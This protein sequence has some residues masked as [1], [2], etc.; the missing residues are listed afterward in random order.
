M[1]NK[2]TQQGIQENNG[3]G[4][5][6]LHQDDIVY[7]RRTQRSAMNCNQSCFWP[8]SED[9][10]VNIP[11]NISTEFSVEQT[12]VI[13]EAMQEFVTLTCIQFISRTT[14]HDY[15]NIFPGDRCWSYFGKI[16]G[17][18]NLGLAKFGCIYKGL[19][20]H[21]LNHAL[22][23][24]HEQAR[25]DRDKY[26]K[27][28][29]EY[30]TAGEQGNFEKVNSN[31]LGLPYDYGSVMHYGPYDFSNAAG[32]PTIVPTPN[33]SVLIGQRV[34]LSNLDVKKIN[35]LYSCNCCSTVLRNPRGNFSS[36][37]YPHS[38]PPNVTCLWLVKIPNVKVFL[39][40]LVFDLQPSPN[41][42]SDYIRI[43]DGNSRNARL[44][45]DKFCGVGQLPAVVSSGS[46]MLVE[47]VSDEDTA[48]KG[49]TAS[50][51][52]VICGGTFTNTSGAV[53][54]PNFPRKYPPDQDCLWIISA[55]PGRRISLRM[56]SF[57]LEYTAECNYDRLVLRDGSQN[58]SPR[59]G[60]FCGKM[61]VPA[62]NSTGSFL[63]VEFYTD[64]AF[65]YSGFKLDY[66]IILPS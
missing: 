65:Q 52:Y 43:Y 10:L 15:I 49:F 28:N 39:K 59:V 36:N 19:I 53:T 50:Y 62:F 11:V 42:A 1:Q 37:N 26:V 13:A 51:T 7:R 32:K 33:A 6:Y 61:E 44:L 14:E 30:V 55:P 54:S 17:R 31:N 57:D 22:G 27:I 38:Y 45:I 34:G 35:M 18:Q 25:G 5:T 40:F 47:F 20:Q 24:L 41:C 23:F 2:V 29:W 21:E 66:S 9:G 64:L 16:G 56:D 8:R 3:P 4:E 12:A 46:T 63:R 60:T 48:A 58:H